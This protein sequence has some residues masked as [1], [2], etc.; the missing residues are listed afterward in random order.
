MSILDVLESVVVKVVGVIVVVTTRD[1]AGIRELPR[2]L[3]T[4]ISILKNRDGV[5]LLLEPHR[6]TALS[7]WPWFTVTLDDVLVISKGLFTA[8]IDC[9]P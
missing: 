1:Y 6:I 5:L 3:Q 8:F 9:K 7:T 4:R 2:T